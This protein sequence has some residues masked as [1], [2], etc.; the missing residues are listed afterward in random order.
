[1]KTKLYTG[2]IFYKLF[3]AQFVTEL[4]GGAVAG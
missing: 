1:M 2:I 4:S 3:L